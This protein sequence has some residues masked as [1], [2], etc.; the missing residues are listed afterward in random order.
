MQELDDYIDKVK[1]LPTAPKILPEL[2]AL[3]EAEDVDSERVVRLIAVDP[4]LT[5]NVLRLCNSAMLAGASPVGD[6]QEAVTRLGFK[7]IFQ[8]VAATVGSQALNPAQTGYGIN[9]GELWKHSVTSAVA[10]QLLAQRSGENQTAV[11]T[12][13]LL[14]DIGKI[15]LTEAVEQ[16]YAKLLEDVKDEQTTLLDAEKR[17]LGVQHAEVGGR[18]LA[19]WKFP[20]SI[21]SAVWH[22]HHP[23]AAQPH[24]KLAAHVYLGNMVAYFIGH[25]YGH[26]AFA[27]SGRVEALDLTGIDAATLP[28][29]MIETLEQLKTVEKLFNV[30]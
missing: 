23:A 2:L 21:V 26:Q 27:M 17:L 5:A 3:L 29:L 19:R 7:Q 6:L 25:G 8:I 10:A 16:V 22:H 11:F 9:R 15:V 12:A 1:N 30:T 24:E 4:A 28:H 13:T 20:A 14:H 18:L